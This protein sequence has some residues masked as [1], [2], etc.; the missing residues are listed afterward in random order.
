MKELAARSGNVA[1][2]DSLVSFLY[3]LMRD[4]LPIGTIEA[5][6]LQHIQYGQHDSQFTNGWLANYAKDIADRLNEHRD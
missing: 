2:K 1:S 3:I 4:H 6:M 5:I